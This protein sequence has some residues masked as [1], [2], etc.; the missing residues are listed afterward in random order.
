MA[1]VRAGEWTRCTTTPSRHGFDPPPVRDGKDPV[2]DGPMVEAYCCGKRTPTFQ[3]N[4][5]ASVCLGTAFV[6]KAEAVMRM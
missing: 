3:R 4:D 5:V 6:G 2:M 1:R